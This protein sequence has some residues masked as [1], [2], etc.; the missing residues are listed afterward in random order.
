MSTD[1]LACALFQFHKVRLKGRVQMTVKRA[2]WFQFHK[3]RLK[4]TFIVAIVIA[5]FMFQFHKVRLKAPDGQ[6]P[7]SAFSVS[8]P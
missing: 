1:P 7:K 6:I 8:I 5:I 4:G 3:V 2:T